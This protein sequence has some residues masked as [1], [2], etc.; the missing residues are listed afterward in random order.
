[1]NLKNYK[2]DAGSHWLNIWDNSTQ[3]E[4]G[5]QRQH[6]GEITFC[7]PTEGP[8]VSAP[9]VLLMLLFKDALPAFY[10]CVLGKEAKLLG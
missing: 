6:L 3:K 4:H 8:S 2:N 5:Q 9:A 7:L 1:M 10:I